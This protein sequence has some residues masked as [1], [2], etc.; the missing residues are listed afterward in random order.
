M[1]RLR[2]YVS[3]VGLILSLLAVATGRAWLRWAAIGTI[4]AALLM[5]I[6]ERRRGGGPPR[7]YD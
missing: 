5:R 6:W 1:T 2:L 4:A 7:S 3:V